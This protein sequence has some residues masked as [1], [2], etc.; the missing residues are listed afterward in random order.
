MA[1]KLGNYHSSETKAF[2]TYYHKDKNQMFWSR[3]SGSSTFLQSRLKSTSGDLDKKWRNFM[4][5]PKME[6]HFFLLEIIISTLNTKKVCDSNTGLLLDD[7]ILLNK[8]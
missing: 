5:L 2:L 3:L 1:N 4:V 6:K 8:C 7:G